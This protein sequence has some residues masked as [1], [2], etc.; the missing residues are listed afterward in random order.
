MNA[1][2]TIRKNSLLELTVRYETKTN[3]TN[4]SLAKFVTDVKKIVTKKSVTI[5]VIEND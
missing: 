2:D 4:S 3:L 1:L 5:L